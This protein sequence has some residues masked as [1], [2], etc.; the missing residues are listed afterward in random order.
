MTSIQIHLDTVD[1]FSSDHPF[2]Y[3][4]I[5]KTV[6]FDKIDPL[7]FVKFKSSDTAFKDEL[8]LI[9]KGSFGV[10]ELQ[11]ATIYINLSENEIFVQIP[12]HTI[13][14]EVSGIFVK[15]KTPEAE[16]LEILKEIS[17]K[18]IYKLKAGQF[19]IL[20]REHLLLGRSISTKGYLK[21]PGKVEDM[22][23]W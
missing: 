1:N 22:S 2:K 11:K 19:S 18:E 5:R 7:S 16:R 4:K 6:I 9:E 12:S 23:N 14:I 3:D 10:A 13:K 21:K 15:Y 20:L 8:P 17:L